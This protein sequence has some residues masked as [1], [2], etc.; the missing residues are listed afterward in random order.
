MLVI[1]SGPGI[2]IELDAEKVEKYSG[3]TNLIS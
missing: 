1:P 2:G 3:V